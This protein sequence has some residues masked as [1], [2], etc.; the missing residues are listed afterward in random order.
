MP[1]LFQQDAPKLPSGA[2]TLSAGQCFVPPAGWYW[3][4]GGLYA[5]LQRYDS[6]GQVWR[7]CGDDGRPVRLVYFDGLTT[8]VAN[9]TGCVV[10]AVVTNAGSAYTSAPTV[11]ISAGSASLIAI[12][13]SNISTATTILAGGSGYLYPPILWIEQPP[14]QGGQAGGVT[15]I[16][17]SGGSIS[18]AT[19]T[20]QGAGYVYPPNVVVLNDPRDTAGSGAQVSVALAN[21]QTVTQVLVTNHGN[22]ITSGTVPTISFSGGGGSGAVATAVMDWSVV[23]TTVTTAGAGYGNSAAVTASGAGGYV[24][25]TPA[26]LGGFNS[27]GLSRWRQAVIDVTTGAAGG[28]TTPGIIDGGRY[29]GIPSPVIMG[30]GLI[31]TAAVLSLTMGGANTTVFL[32]PAQL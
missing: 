2:L 4:G 9:T 32:L 6:I 16:S 23:S 20:D 21:A 25:T 8:R 5:N 26:Y 7:F 19:I 24:T 11:T 12:V 22:P 28:L 15:T 27:T 13:G 30:A 14:S 18:T 1:G 3:F 29:Q 10:G 17:G 31:S